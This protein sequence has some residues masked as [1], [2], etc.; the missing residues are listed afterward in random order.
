MSSVGIVGL[1][2]V[3]KNL[4][5]NI[6]KNRDVHVFNRTHPKMYELVNETANVY[7]HGTILDM[8]DS[9]K[10]PRTIMTALPHGN[11]TDDSL[12]NLVTILSPGD[13]IVDL[14]NEHY[15]VSRNRNAR[16]SC[17]D[18]NYLGVGISGG[19]RN[20]PALMVG[21]RW[22]V[23]LEHHDFFNS[24]AKNVAYMGE[25]PGLGHFT[26]M[27]HNGIEYGMLQGIADIFAYCGQDSKVME[28]VMKEASE[29][30]ISGFLINSARDVTKM[31]DVSKIVDVAEM[32]DTGSWCSIFGLT[33]DISTPVI[34]AAL[35][36]RITSK[37]SRFYKTINNKDLMK[38]VNTAVNALRFVF[39]SSIM[40]GYSLMEHTSVPKETIRNAWSAGTIIDCPM[41]EGKFYKIL[42]DT[43]MDARVFSIQCA[44]SRIPCPS[45]QA[46]LTQYDYTRQKR[47]SMNFLMAQRNYFGQ[48]TLIEI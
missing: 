48:H 10:R 47:T 19:A 9:M 44:S 39:A 21:G 2:P 15:K 46:A 25:D 40:E 18:I 26:K 41:I 20:G 13:T 17:R 12:N 29:S 42:D 11:I 33:H 1:G 37:H 22:D 16:C 14:A 4:S 43:S 27:V 7:G 23:F 34:N 36:A 3:G 38:D 30:D 24:F 35:N 5:I 32:N 28:I 6:E 8:V 31:Y 45:V